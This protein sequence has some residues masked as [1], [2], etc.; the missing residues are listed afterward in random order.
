ML[1]ECAGLCGVGC[2]GRVRGD[3]ADEADKNQI[4]RGPSPL[5]HVTQHLP[6]CGWGDS[7][8]EHGIQ[9]GLVSS[10]HAALTLPWRFVFPLSRTFHFYYLS[11]MSHIQSISNPT[12]YTCARPFLA[13]SVEETITYSLLPGLPTSPLVSSGLSSG[14][15]SVLF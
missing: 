1:V 12:G 11:C 6:H 2:T 9:Y 15:T 4:K 8:G 7:E 3:Q 13:T 5:F 14:A 10:P